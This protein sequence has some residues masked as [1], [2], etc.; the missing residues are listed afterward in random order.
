MTLWKAA[1]ATAIMNRT[2]KR[3]SLASTLEDFYSA[4]ATYPHDHER[5]AWESSALAKKDREREEIEASY[6]E[7]I[8]IACRDVLSA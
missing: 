2:E 5:D 8:V 3:N 4:V 7:R 1:K 6:R